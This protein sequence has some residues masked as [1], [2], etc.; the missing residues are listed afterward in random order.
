MIGED[1]GTVENEVSAQ[2][3]TRGILGTTLGWF[4]DMPPEEYEPATVAALTTHDLPTAAGVITGADSAAIHRLGRR[5]DGDRILTRLRAMAPGAVT[6]PETIVE[7][8]RTLARAPTPLVLAQLDD[9]VCALA[10]PNL[11]GTVDEWPN[12]CLPLPTRPG[13]AEVTPHRTGRGRRAGRDQGPLGSD[14]PTAQPPR[15]MR[16]HRPRRRSRHR[17][18]RP[19]PDRPAQHRRGRV[20]RGG[21]PV[22]ARP[23]SSTGRW[24]GW[25]GP[26]ACSCPTASWPPPG[27]SRWPASWPWSRRRSPPP[28]SAP[29][30]GPW[31]VAGPRSS[32]RSCSRSCHRLRTWRASPATASC[33]PPRSRAPRSPPRRGGWSEA[34]AGCCSWPAWRR[35]SA[36]S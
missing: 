14:S 36:R 27:G 15:H 26:R 5:F 7:A 33:W 28:H 24:R 21:A 29:R 1:L 22:G 35:A 34:T 32:P 23:A 9:A 18:P 13:R 2:L 17:P 16:R 11:P 3:R 19:L 4:E 10:R 31:P 20:R 12:W 8:Y 25:T 30:A 6:V